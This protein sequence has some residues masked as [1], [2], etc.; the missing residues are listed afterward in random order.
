MQVACRSNS[1]RPE[2][3][4]CLRI[5]HHCSSLLCEST[6]H[7]LGNAILVLRIWWRGFVA[8]TAS[9]KNSSEQRIVIFS[10]SIVTSKPFDVVT[11]IFNLGFET[12]ECS[13]TGF[14]SLVCKNIDSCMAG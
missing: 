5:E 9:S 8:D 2:M 6:D 10:S 14:R 1:F 4:R 12:L 13:D 11:P 7:S 3:L